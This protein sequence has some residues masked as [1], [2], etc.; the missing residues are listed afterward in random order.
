MMHLLSNAD[1]ES[2]LEDHFLYQ[3]ESTR[4]T[5]AHRSFFSSCVDLALRQTLSQNG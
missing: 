2:Q 1:I 4:H 5:V 3:A